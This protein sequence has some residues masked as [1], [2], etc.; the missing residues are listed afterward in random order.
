MRAY[1]HDIEPDGATR[2]AEARR[3]THEAADALPALAAGR[4][5][6]ITPDGM[7]SLQRTAGNRGV[8]AAVTEVVSSGGRPLDPDTRTDMESRFGHDFGSVRV[9]DDSRATESAKAVQA[10]AYTVGDDIV[11]QRAHYAPGTDAGRRTLAH[12]LTHVVQQRSGPVDGTPQPDGTRVSDP[13]DRFEQEA[14]SNADV[15][16]QRQEMA[17]EEEEEELA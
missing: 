16:L 9:H 1:D 10:H 2:P 13:S 6:A 11:F 12:E 14:A 3:P 8:G 17:E 15:V 4:L 5:D 7:L